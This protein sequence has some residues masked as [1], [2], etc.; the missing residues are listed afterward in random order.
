[1]LRSVKE[2]LS[3]SQTDLEDG[4]VL[5]QRD[6]FTGACFHAQQAAEKALKGFMVYSNIPHPKK[7]DLIELN[8]LCITINT[9]FNGLREKLITLNQF[10]IPSRYPDAA[11]GMAPDGVPTKDLSRKALDYARDVFDFCSD[12]MKVAVQQKPPEPQ[13]R[14]YEPPDR[15]GNDRDDR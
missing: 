1:M 10:Y 7:H 5:F 14:Y 8:D 13:P 9:A 6:R 3:F 2:W 15:N 11:A 4:E 12:R